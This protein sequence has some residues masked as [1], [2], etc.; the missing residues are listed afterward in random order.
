ML[1]SLGAVRRWDNDVPEAVSAR[2]QLQS[3]AC[4][5]PSPVTKPSPGLVPVH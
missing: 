3:T 4:F 1:G 2:A 5:G